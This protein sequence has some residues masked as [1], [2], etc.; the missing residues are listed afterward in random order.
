MSKIAV[1]TDSNA[2]LTQEMGEKLGIKIV[3]MPFFIDGEEYLEGVTLDQKQFFEMLDKGAKVSTSQ[4]AIGMVTSMWDELLEENDYVVYFPMSSGLSKSCETATIASHSD[5]YE[6]KVFVIDNG[7]ISVPQAQAVFDC[8]EM[9]K[10]GLNIHTIVKVLEETGMNHDIFLMLDTLDYLKRGGRITPTAAALG[11]FLKL[12]PVLMIKGEKLDS[13]RMRNRTI[14]GA[15]KIMKEACL[16]CIE[17]YMK[18]IDGDTSNIHFEVAYS[19]TD[20]TEALAFVEE[21]KSEFGIKNVDMLQLSLSIACHTGPGALGM[22]V[23][24]AIPNDIKDD[25]II[26]KNDEIL[27]ELR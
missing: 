14:D 19:G 12:K 2:G 8:Q 6:G 5:E 3:P 21:I 11:G 1:M 24:K 4:P 17:G 7:R 27:K 22:A 25:I 16:K 23:S 9:I 20:T 26:E 10:K 13:Y 18:D 15:K